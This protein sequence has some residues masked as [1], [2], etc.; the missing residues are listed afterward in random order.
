[1]TAKIKKINIIFTLILGVILGFSA[2]SQIKAI[3]PSPTP[4]PEESVTT[5]PTKTVIDELKKIEQLKEK[6]ATKVAEIRATDK[7]A[8]GGVV[9]SITNS[10]IT[11]TTEKGEMNIS[12]ADDLQVFSST[13][14][15]QI[16]SSVKK[17]KEG[18]EISVFGYF[19]QTKTSLTAKYVYLPKKILYSIGKIVDIDKTNY[20]I[21]VKEPQGNTIV[22]IEIYSKI[23]LFTKGKG[24]VKIGFSK[25]KV[26]DSVHVMGTPN[27]KE[28]NRLSALRI[29]DL[30]FDIPQTPTPTKEIEKE[31]A[32]V[33]PLEKTQ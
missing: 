10:A 23:S 22:D 9:K 24:L 29:I 33:T 32:T 27:T 26:G 18:D 7:G 16:E 21:T 3:S 2:T 6:I 15:G 4:T 11:I 14:G 8:S 19:D 5:V 30:T 13:E 28:E 20:T 25:L 31:E 1:M 12:Y 17:I